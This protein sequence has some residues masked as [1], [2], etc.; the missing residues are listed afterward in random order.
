MQNVAGTT[1]CIM[2][3]A[4]MVN[5]WPS[6]KCLYQQH[7][8]QT[9]QKVLIKIYVN[10]TRKPKAWACLQGGRVTLVLG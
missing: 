7:N 3:K 4:K 9:L 8:I 2:G 5:F 10:V 6:K 1:R